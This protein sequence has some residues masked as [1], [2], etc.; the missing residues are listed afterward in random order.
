MSSSKDTSRIAA[1]L[2]T[3]SSCTM[4]R[5]DHESRGS[6]SSRYQP[7]RGLGPGTSHLARHRP[8]SRQA[9]CRFPRKEP[10]LQRVE[11]LLAIPGISEKKWKAIRDKVEVKEA[12]GNSGTK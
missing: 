3:S 7:E 1:R 5:H 12:A 8:H 9:D 4:D 2:S 6:P 11:E 10:R